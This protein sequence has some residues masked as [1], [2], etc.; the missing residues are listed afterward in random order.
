MEPVAIGGDL[1]VRRLLA[2]YRA[3]I[4]PWSVDP[5]TW[6]SPDPRG[7]FEL[8]RFHIPRSLER[9]LRRRPYEVTFNRAFRRRF[10]KTPSD[11]RPQ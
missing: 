1:S 2:A 4:F 11:F 3:G 6:W 5:I 7:I 10:G 9:T 8:D